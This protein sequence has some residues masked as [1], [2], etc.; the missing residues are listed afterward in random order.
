[1]K[2]RNPIDI[3]AQTIPIYPNGSFFLSSRLRYERL[4]QIQVR[5][6]YRLR[7]VQRIRISVG[8]E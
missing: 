2:P 5:L 8:I 1:M 7:G 3:I 4:F 6:K